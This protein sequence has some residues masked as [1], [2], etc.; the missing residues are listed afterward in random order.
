MAEERSHWLMKSEP[1]VYSID[2][3]QRDGTTPW[4]SIRNYEARNFMRDRMG[5][6]DRILFYHSNATPPAIVGVMEVASGAYPDPT[7]FDPAHPYHDPKS[8]LDS[9][10]WMLVDVQFERKF[11]RPVT[12]DALAAD[13]LLS[14]MTLFKRNRLSIT[15][16]TREEYLRVL[17]LAGERE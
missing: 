9:P 12:R 8:R 17:D 16:V 3:L 13:G 10:T 14:Q 11:T 4:D 1:E 7:Q 5:I 6:G 2:D 15:P